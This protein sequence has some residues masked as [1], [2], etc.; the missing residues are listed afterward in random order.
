MKF[1]VALIAGALSAFAYQPFA[2]YLRSFH[3]DATGALVSAVDID[4][5]ACSVMHDFVITE[6][7]VV[8]V[9]SPL[10]FDL[11]GALEGKAPFHWDSNHGT[12]VG[13][14]ARGGDQV[15]WFEVA[16]GYVNHFWNAWEENDTITFSGSCVV[17]TSY[18]SGEGGAADDS[19]ADAE[20]GRPTRFVVDLAAQTAETCQVLQFR[21]DLSEAEIL[22]GCH[23]SLQRA[24]AVSLVE[25]DW[26][27]SRVAELLGWP[28]PVWPRRD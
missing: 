2:P 19:A 22:K 15:D 12:R 9:E 5:P 17:G 10:L 3:I 4:T 11:A 7:H 6:R 14:M 23:A 21:D 28:M 1:L 8:F 18:T 27:V 20:P 24:G 16:D 25:A 26:T 13:V